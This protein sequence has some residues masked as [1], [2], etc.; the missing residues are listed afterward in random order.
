MKLAE[1]KK[2]LKRAID[3]LNQGRPDMSAERAFSPVSRYLDIDRAEAER[4]MIRR[5]PQPVC[6][7]SDL[8]APGDWLARDC[9][10]IPV[11]V[12]RDGEG[13]LRAFLNVCRHRGMQVAPCGRGSDRQSFSCPYHAW[14][15][16]GSGALKN[17]PKSFGFPDLEK[18]RYGLT[19]L[20]VEERAGLVWVVADPALS[21]MRI[22][23]ALG[24]FADE[25]ENFGF[26]TH[27]GYAPRK[28]QTAANWK[29]LADGSLEDYHFQTLHQKTSAPFFVDTAQLLDI[30]GKNIRFFLIKRV[31]GR[32]PEEEI[33][34][35]DI[36][37]LGN[38]LYFF[39]P[40][41]W[42][43]IQPDHAMVT[44]IHP[45]DARN[46]QL[47]EIALLP[48]LPD[49]SDRA[50]WDENVNLFRNTLDE[51]YVLAEKIQAGLSTGA[52][53]FFS[54]GRYEQ[55]LAFFHQQVEAEISRD[56]GVQ[57]NEDRLTDSLV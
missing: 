38:I 27:V 39:F 13:R 49:D 5:H 44:F 47:E 36:R 6:A 20:A 9:S 15:Y 8:T 25:I 56:G 34:R 22:S 12:T 40:A 29:L 2:L 42:I 31:L 45:L 52:N 4:R 50:Y 33:A 23:D 53:E 54:F 14:R 19:P 26:R 16:D 51:D 7:S 1:Q 55:A 43:L 18:S 24:A 11:L 46:T 35:R 57:V 10:G 3:A 21:A 30:S 37:E 17:I 48:R 28:F 32:L 41:T